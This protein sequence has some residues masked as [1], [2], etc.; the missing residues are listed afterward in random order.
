MR[1]FLHKTLIQ[2]PHTF[3]HSVIRHT[4]INL[5]A[6]WLRQVDQSQVDQN[7]CRI[8]WIW[9][10][11]AISMLRFKP[12][13]FA[14]CSKKIYQMLTMTSSF[15][16]PQVP[17]LTSDSG[18]D[19]CLRR[20]SYKRLPDAFRRCHARTG[21]GP[22]GSVSSGGTGSKILPLNRCWKQ[23]DGNCCTLKLWGWIIFAVCCLFFS[24]SIF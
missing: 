23:D 15:S 6:D 3:A 14:K 5:G 12:L 24:C 17:F 9:S 11:N 10:A 22:L 4:A 16:H 20:I 18:I 2:G 7:Q 8:W 1:F 21:N 13:Q 19:F